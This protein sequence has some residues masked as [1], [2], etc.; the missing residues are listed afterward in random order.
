M[1]SKVCRQCDSFS[2]IDSTVAVQTKGFGFSFQTARNSVIGFSRS[3]TL[4]KE[5]RRIRWLVNSRNQRSIRFSQ[6][7]LVG[8]KCDT[9][10]GWRFSQAWTLGCVCAYRSY[11]SPDASAPLLGTPGRG[12]AETARSP[13]G[14]A[15]H[16]TVRSPVLARLPE[17]RTTRSFHCVYSHASGFRSGINSYCPAICW[18]LH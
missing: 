7:E 11:P 14:D 10:R 13:G 16:S 12:D 8:T 5:P 6:L 17:R 3:S 18:T 9:K 2:T 4:R 15:A 1:C